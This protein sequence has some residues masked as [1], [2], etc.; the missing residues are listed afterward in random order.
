MRMSSVISYWSTWPQRKVIDKEVK[1]RGPFSGPTQQAKE[2]FPLLLSAPS[3]GVGKFF[4]QLQGAKK[5]GSR[6]RSARNALRQL[7]LSPLK[8]NDLAALPIDH[9][10]QTVQS[11]RVSQPA[12]RLFQDSLCFIKREWDRFLMHTI[13]QHTIPGTTITIM[14]QIFEAISF[15]TSSSEAKKIT[16]FTAIQNTLLY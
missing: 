8:R 12:T 4:A 6:H 1:M 13:I 14:P 2:V 11:M 15:T 3:Q 7:K 10:E 5:M 9:R 16:F